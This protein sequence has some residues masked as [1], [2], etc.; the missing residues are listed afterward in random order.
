[1]HN[2]YTAI[3]PEEAV[4]GRCRRRRSRRAPRPFLPLPLLRES[5]VRCLSLSSSPPLSRASS[6][7]DN[8]IMRISWFAYF[9]KRCH[10]AQESINNSGGV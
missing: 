8:T 5:L 6:Y 3:R 10:A 9:R 7:R 2:A 4:R 1:M